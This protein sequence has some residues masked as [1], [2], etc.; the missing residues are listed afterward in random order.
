M[1][2]VARLAG[3]S[4]GTVSHVLNKPE[5]VAPGTRDR[6]HAAIA[7]LGF[8]RNG[9][10]RSLVRGGA[11]TIGLIVAD[12]GNSLFVD[13]ARGVDD[14]G[15][16]Q[17]MSVLLANSDI[18]VTRQDHY[19]TLFDENWVSGILLA[20]LDAPLL[21]ARAPR[22]HGRPVVLVNW[23]AE[24]YCGVL[25]DEERGGYL[26]ARHLIELGRTRLAYFGG[27]LTLTALARRLRGAQRAVAETD[28][29]SLVH[30]PTD[31]LKVWEGR[32]VAAGLV[33]RPDRPDG[34]V[35]A[36]DTLAVACILELTHRGLRVPEDVAVTGYD[37]N[38]FA[39]DNPIPVTTVRQRGR[40]MGRLA[41][42]LLMEEIRDA[43]G[44]RHRTVVIEPELVA[45]EST[46]KSTQQSTQ[47]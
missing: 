21:T 39:S 26:A 27:P 19:L 22:A 12:I 17:G 38:H 24:G 35:A 3:V 4:Q 15:Q 2:D 45:R 6:V 31:N 7:E 30:V 40:E 13:I 47:V 14:A 1:R 11:D 42:D 9:A 33:D 5:I 20:P 18:D 10:A 23:A 16:R 25:V 28:G 36:A 41:T 37:D 29:V 32:R 8:V 43:E 44:H 46:Q 34:I